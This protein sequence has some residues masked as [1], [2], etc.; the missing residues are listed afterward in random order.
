MDPIEL[1]VIQQLEIM[2]HVVGDRRPDLYGAL[3]L[4]VQ[5]VEAPR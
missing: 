1:K 2:K 4:P 5:Q 3:T